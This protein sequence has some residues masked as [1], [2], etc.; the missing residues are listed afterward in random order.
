VGDWEGDLL[1]GPSSRSAIGTLV[2]RC[3]RYVLLVH[4]PLGHGAEQCRLALSAALGAL[5]AQLRQTL[6]WDQGSE[7]AQHDKLAALF[8]DG[9]FFAHPASPRQRPSNENTAIL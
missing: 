6:T 9:I 4:L 2:E 3:S 8:G 7:M 1:V 5:P